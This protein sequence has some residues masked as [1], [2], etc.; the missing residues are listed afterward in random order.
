[1]HYPAFSLHHIRQCRTVEL[2]LKNHVISSI[3]SPFFI[4]STMYLFD[5]LFFYLTLLAYSRQTKERPDLMKFRDWET[6][7]Y[8]RAVATGFYRSGI[9]PLAAVLLASRGVTEINEAREMLGESPPVFHDPLLMAGMC[10]AVSRINAGIA[11][12]ERIAVY[13]D[14]DVDGMTS[15]AMLTDWLRSKGADTE[16]YIPG[17]FDEGY[18]LNGAALDLLKSNGVDLVI[19]VDCG[20]T[21]IEEA[22][23]AK[24]IGLG[25]V[26]TDHHECRDELPD[27]DAV[28]D[29]KRPDCAYPF[30]SLAGVGV[31]YKLIC[32][33]E[34]QTAPE[35][36]LRRYGD[37]VAVGTVADVTPVG[38]ENR[39]FIR[40]GLAVLNDGPRSGLRCL[41]REANPEQGRVTAATI[42]FMLAPR[43]NAAGRM[44]S[45]GMSVDLLLSEDESEARKLAT[46]LC[47]LNT[48]RRNLE[49]EIYEQAVAMLPPA[50]LTGPDGP[51][52]LAR[53]GWHQGVT[54]IVAAK[55]AE[56]YLVPAI[57]ISIDEN[58]TGR[59]SCRSY[60]GFSIYSA[61]K[62]CEDILETFGGHDMA[63]G[64]TVTEDKID[65]LRRRVSARYHDNIETAQSSGLAM[66]FEV[67][68]PELLEV[69]NI[70][71]LD[72]L[73]PYGAGFPAPR[74]CIRNAYITSVTSIGAGKHTRLR[75]DK[76]GK[77][78]D[79]IYFSTPSGEIG[80]SE[81]MM[82]DVAFEPQVNE[83][84]GRTTAQLSL[85]D[86]RES[87]S[88]EVENGKWKVES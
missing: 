18:G 9:N 36:I 84:R 69:Q 16:V 59:G 61:L 65:E 77:S 24:E 13:G 60:G 81:G 79:C 22:I 88:I 40:Q 55:I 52:V 43:L 7:G 37:L 68:K 58:R 83:F 10:D 85:L 74:L 71:E 41:I 29:P 3:K 23:H 75:I 67:E 51:I 66:D 11:G 57:M 47:R 64:V 25:L 2:W 32:A 80:V 28:I 33:L 1:M 38:G 26:I 19:T 44:G 78:F 35:A 21:A 48:V 42:S 4:L 62:S 14:Y 45:P 12:G 50:G 70:R 87:G 27:A 46:E 76:A 8:D 86:I 53:R 63:A 15:S 30:K 82:A 54:G 20:I 49:N 6:G 34:P 17:R 5:I 56:R 31:V 73:E 39:G 72:K